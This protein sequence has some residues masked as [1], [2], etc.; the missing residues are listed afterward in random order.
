MLS[1][2]NDP[3]LVFGA[4]GLVSY[5]SVLIGS[6]GYFIGATL[7]EHPEQDAFTED[8]TSRAWPGSNR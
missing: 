2:S 8:R 1:P 4:Y 5:S 6:D 7:M 3:A